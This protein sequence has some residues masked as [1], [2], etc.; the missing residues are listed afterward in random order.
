[1]NFYSKKDN[2]IIKAYIKNGKSTK[3]NIAA[4]SKILKRNPEAIYQKYLNI[5]KSMGLVPSRKK[6]GTPAK[7]AT[8]KKGMKLEFKA[9]HIV[10]E[11][12]KLIVYI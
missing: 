12:N 11:E 9:T 10:L 2:E 4:L 3:E 8:L 1:M 7:A 5:K 6:N